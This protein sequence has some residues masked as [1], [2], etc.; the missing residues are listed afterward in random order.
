[1]IDFKHLEN[2]ESLTSQKWAFRACYRNSFSFFSPYGKN[3]EEILRFCYT[4][5]KGYDIGDI[6]ERNL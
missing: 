5:M 6:G 1:M 4:N 3:V 2:V